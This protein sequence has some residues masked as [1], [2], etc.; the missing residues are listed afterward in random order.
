MIRSPLA[1]F[2]FFPFLSSCSSSNSSPASAGY[3]PPILS[4]W[5]QDEADDKGFDEHATTFRKT[6]GQ[7][8][9]R[10]KLTLIETANGEKPDD[11]AS[12]KQ[13]ADSSLAEAKSHA[14]TLQIIEEKE[15]TFRG[16][17]A[18]LTRTQDE[19]RNAQRERKI[20]RVADGKNTFMLDQTLRGNPIDDAARKE[21]DAAWE[22]L[23]SDMKIK[24]PTS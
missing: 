17:P 9:M 4:D 8:R 24:E 23:S 7:T 3:T 1:L 12:L 22:K 2:A 6:V 5:Q 16:F 18:L 15:T 10:M 11:L 13:H 14:P 20:L 21:A 19:Y